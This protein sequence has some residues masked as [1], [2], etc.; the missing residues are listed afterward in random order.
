MRKTTNRTTKAESSRPRRRLGEAHGFSLV[1]M[2]V[3]AGIMMLVTAIAVPSIRWEVLDAK[4]SSGM[5]RVQGAL[6][7]ARDAA[8]T[9]RRTM[10]VQFLDPGAIQVLRA[11]GANRTPLFRLDL[12][13]DIGYRVFHGVP[14]TPD[15][16]GNTGGVSFGGLTTVYFLADGSVTDST[17]V[18]VSGTLF[19]GVGGQPLSARAVTVLGPTGRVQS[20]RWDGLS[21][22]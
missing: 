18:P 10:E 14:D 8:M 22:R 6:R 12:V 19:L 11:D 3:V 13:D 1:D 20:Y 15:R 16:F 21:W 7:Q 2:M 4:A 9:Q 17:G 5:R